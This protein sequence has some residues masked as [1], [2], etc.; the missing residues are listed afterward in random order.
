MVSLKLIYYDRKGLAETSR[1]VMLISGVPFEDCRLSPGDMEPVRADLGPAAAGRPP[2]YLEVTRG[3]TRDVLVNHRSIERFLARKC[4]LMGRDLSEEAKIDS[5]CESIRGIQE[6]FCAPGIAGDPEILARLKQS[7]EGL[8]AL[9]GGASASYSVGNKTSLA[10]I[11]LYTSVTTGFADR[12]AVLEV[13]G[14]VK[15]IRGI[16]TKVSSFK[17]VRDWVAKYPV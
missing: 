4:G 3:E 11:V 5:I 16:L 6:D 8:A 14:S 12:Q 10:D 2:P 13:A 15:K 17:V 1:L 9:M 7:F